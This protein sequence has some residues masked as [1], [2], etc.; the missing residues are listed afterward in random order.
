MQQQERIRGW[1]VSRD[2][3]EMQVDAAERHGELR[4][5]VE[6]PFLRPPVKA[7]APIFDK[8][9]HISD[10]GAVSPR[11][12]WRLVGKT[13]ALEPLVQVGNG[14][15]GNPEGKGLRLL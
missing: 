9:P 14:L 5:G 4:K 7:V 3:Q 6:P 1:P 11:F 10:I 13:H 2:V 8:L 15:P 12:A